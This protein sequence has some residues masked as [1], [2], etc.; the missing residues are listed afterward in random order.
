M[1]PELSEKRY[2][3]IGEVAQA[4]DVNTSLI[5]FWEKE[6]KQISPKKNKHGVRYYSKS[7]IEAVQLIYHLVKER[8]FTLDGAKEHLKTKPKTQKQIDL[9]QKL[10]GI[11]AALEELKANL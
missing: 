1:Q 3:S 10:Q 9:L 6:F 2:H 11:R 8:G 4:F 5:R 7:D